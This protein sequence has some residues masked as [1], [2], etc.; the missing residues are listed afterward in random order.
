MDDPFSLELE[1]NGQPI[2]LDIGRLGLSPGRPNLLFLH[3]SGGANLVWT[4]LLSRLSRRFN[5]LAVELPGHGRT[6]GPFLPDIPSAAQWFVRVI[7]KLEPHPPPISIGASLGGAIVLE[8]ALKAP[9]LISGMIL[10][11]TA[12]RLS[13]DL[14]LI[15]SLQENHS[16][17]LV[18]FNKRLFSSGTSPRLVQRSLEALSHV[19]PDVLEHD[20]TMSLGFD[21]RRFLSRIDKPVLVICGDQDTLTPPDLAAELASGFRRGILSIIPEAGHMVILE[22]PLAVAREIEQFVSEITD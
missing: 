13:V 15:S 1:L 11:S 8:T 17:G 3:G 10:I 20:L 6:P 7:H 16:H 14:T 22:Q 5:A 21:R 18:E 4:G 2:G 12:A 9:H 19:P